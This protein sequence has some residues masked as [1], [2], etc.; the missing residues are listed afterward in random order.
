MRN[1]LAILGGR[2]AVTLK[3]F[4]E[5]EPPYTWDYPII[6]D[7]EIEA[8]VKV[9]RSKRLC[10]LPNFQAGRYTK[11]SQL[12]E[13]FAK[14]VGVDY[15]VAV[16]SGTAALH[17][18]VAA[19]GV[20]PGD[21]VITSPY[22][23]VASASC[24]L[25]Q[26]GIP[27]FADIDP[28]T[29]NLDPDRVEEKITP[30]T[31][32]IIAVHLYG[33]PASMR[34]LL[35]ISEKHGLTL[36]EDCAQAHG[37]TFEGR[38][39]GS[40]GHIGCFSFQESKNMMCGEGGI[41]TTNDAELA[42]KTSCVRVF[43]ERMRKGERRDYQAR[44]LGWNYRMTEIQAAIALVQLR[45]LDKTNE[46]RIKHAN[47]LTGRLRDIPSIDAPHVAP[48]A[49]HVYYIYTPIFREDIA[50]IPRDKFVE[51]IKAEGVPVFTPWPPLYA[52][53]IFQD[54]SGYGK[55]C[56]FRCPIY[57]GKVEYGSRL[58]PV[59][60]QRCKDTFNLYVHPPLNV[61]LMEQYAEA[62]RKVAENASALR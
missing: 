55:G 37:A 56:P 23:F 54:L 48:N 17:C 15:A 50:G 1:K 45:R 44:T 7:E 59:A 16:N 30:R 19:A 36:I 57:E 49:T 31:K 61:E 2:Q 58:C 28:I 40:I 62:M 18:A 6:E 21:E 14:Y 3:R 51:A 43:G 39:V 29:Y 27:V 25:H 47:L 32:A 22:T 41:I 12:E 46:I 38:K 20:G 5:G 52:L 33:Q 34:R 35:E 9:L 26:N 11:N 8:V 24:I 60:E 13:E 42:E 4:E 53:P 10:Y